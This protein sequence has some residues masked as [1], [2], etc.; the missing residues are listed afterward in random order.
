MS[1]PLILADSSSYPLLNLFWTFLE[2]FIWILWFVLLFRVIGDIFRSHDLS[3]GWK[4][5]WVLLVIILPYLGVLIYLIA[6]GSEMHTRDVQRAQQADE[7]VRTY[8]RQT[9]STSPSEELAKLA[10]L[11][12]QGVLT[13]A[14]FNDQKAKLLA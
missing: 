13:E 6:R 4:A 14:E 7:A 12:D 5:A 10:A 1:T 11:R 8:I 3:G 9:A 2:F